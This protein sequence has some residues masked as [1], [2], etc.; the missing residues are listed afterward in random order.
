MRLFS[1]ILKILRGNVVEY[2]IEEF[3]VSLMKENKYDIDII[4]KKIYSKYPFFKKG[5]LKK[6]ISELISKKINNEKIGGIWFKCKNKWKLTST[7]RKDLSRGFGDG[8]YWKD[9]PVPSEL[10]R[11]NREILVPHGVE[12]DRYQIPK[13]DFEEIE[14]LYEQMIVKF[15]S[16]FPQMSDSELKRVIKEELSGLGYREEMLRKL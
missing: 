16:K 1:Y 13:N 14:K 12:P 11:A 9:A 6:I 5:D 8:N 3:I 4:A 7:D 10:G 15:K 2:P